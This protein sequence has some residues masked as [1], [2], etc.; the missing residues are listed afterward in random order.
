MEKLLGLIGD[1]AR[2]KTP[3]LLVRLQRN[4]KAS[5]V[6]T[7][8][9]I[10]LGIMWLQAGISKLWGAENSAFLHNNGAGVAG[11]AHGVGPTAGG[12]FSCTP[13]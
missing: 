1:P 13:L 12:A 9:R 4:K 7:A 10:W 3:S 5:L 2:V 6:W 11:F 8:M